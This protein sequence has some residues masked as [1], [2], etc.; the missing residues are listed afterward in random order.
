MQDGQER[1]K[2]AV[3]IRASG[4]ED[5]AAVGEINRQAF[6]GEAEADLVAALRREGDAVIELV[7]L[8]AGEPLGHIL[9]SPLL[10]P[11]GSL[12]LAPLAV[13]PRAQ[14]RGIGSA[15]VRAALQEARRQGWKAV[16]VLGEP[17]YYGRFG[18]SAAL[19][20]PF[21]TPF[22]PEAFQALELETGALKGK[23]CRLRYAAPFDAL[24]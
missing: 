10:A 20:G 24:G 22:P 12:A 15:L 7:A 9:L 11:E 2:A 3:E 16:F 21:E 6:G 5:E 23:A 18:F 4:R 14:G 19:A 8:E 1:G 13:L 17:A